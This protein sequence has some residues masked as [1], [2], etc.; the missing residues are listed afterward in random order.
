M[1]ASRSSLDGLGYIDGVEQNFIAHSKT[2]A[3]MLEVEGNYPLFHSV[4]HIL[5]AQ[6]A[7]PASFVTR[8]HCRITSQLAQHQEND[9]AGRLFKH[10]VA[11]IQ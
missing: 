2:I 3:S 1:L 6:R 8:P 4:N 7:K 5:A 10:T 11:I 9:R